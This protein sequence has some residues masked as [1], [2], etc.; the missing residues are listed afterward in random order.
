MENRRIIKLTKK[1]LAEAEENAFNY[2]DN[3]DFKQYAGQS[4]ISVPGKEN[5][6]EYGNEKPTDAFAD[7]ISSQ[8]YN[9]YAGFAYRP[10]ALKE[11]DINTDGIDD[12]YNNDELV[13]LG[14]ENQNDDL[15]KIP[16][17]VK[18]KMDILIDSM[19]M[20]SPK[21][22]AIVLNKMIESFDLSS[23]PYAWLKE[24]RLKI[25]TKKGMKNNA[26]S[27]I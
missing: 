14:N 3:A 21:Q 1:Q 2:L 20:L 10:Y 4:E 9:R 11:S 17:G 8:A 15:V 25:N 18:N 26:S 6:E 27:H 16:E 22:Q 24:L 7:K 12:F 13:T 5:D 19:Q 23:L